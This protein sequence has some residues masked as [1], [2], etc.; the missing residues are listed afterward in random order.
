MLTDPKPHVIIRE[1]DGQGAV[2]QC[3]ARGLDFLTI[4]VA[5]FL[6]VEGRVLRVGF[7]QRELLISASAYLDRQRP[8]VVPEVR[9][10][11]MGHAPRR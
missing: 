11:A 2:F 7:Q 8:I 9:V 1:I 5:Q 3:H 4:A 6:E 10:R